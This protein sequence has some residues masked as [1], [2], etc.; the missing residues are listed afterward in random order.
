M[1]RAEAGDLAEKVI[2]H[3]S[4][5]VAQSPA[6]FLKLPI[7]DL[8]LSSHPSPE[9]LPAEQLRTVLR[10]WSGLPKVG[11]VPNVL[12]IK[13]E[14]VWPALGYLILIDIDEE[15]EDFRYALYGSRIAAVS[16]F[17]M[18]GRSIWDIETTSSVQNF[19]AACY[20]AAYRMRCPIYTVHEAP[21]IITISHWHRLILP[22]GLDGQIKRFLVCNL[23][24]S[25]GD[26]R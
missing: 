13:P 14:D 24:I 7:N 3:L 8:Y 20:I 18:T 2:R 25:N 21:R 9:D 1:S 5:N 19:F 26:V 15:N 17:D 16:G 10:F 12:K 6:A 23:P 4:R 22:L 11:G